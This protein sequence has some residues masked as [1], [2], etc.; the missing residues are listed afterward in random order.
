MTMSKSFPLPLLLAALTAL[1]LLP[2]A[3]QDEDKKPEADA[4]AE[5]VTI[6]ISSQ[7]DK[8]YYEAMA[9]AYAK[10]N[11]G[12]DARVVAYGFQEL[13][14]KLGAS[15]KTQTGL[16]DIVQIDEAFFGAFLN[17]PSPFVDLTERVKE[18]GLDKDLVENR[19]KLFT[20]EGKV[21]GLPQSLS[22]YVMFYRKD[23]FKDYGLTPKMF[24][25]WDDLERVGRTVAE[26]HGIATMSMDPTYF[27]V[28]LRQ[29]GSDLF[30]KDGK[31]LPDMEKATKLLEWMVKITKEGIAVLPERG[32]IFD[33]LFFS[34]QV[35]NDEVL[36]IMGADWYGLDLMPQFAPEL[37][38]KWGI[39]PIP[40][41]KKGGPRTSCFAGQA[42]MIVNGSDKTDEAWDFLHWVMTD[43]EA[44]A[45]RYLMG[46]S[47]PAYKPAWKD[48]RLQEGTEYFDGAAMGKVLI[49]LAKDIPPVAMSPNRPKALFLMQ[50]NYFSSAIYEVDT[51]ANILKD[52][53]KQIDE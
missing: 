10:K 45:K 41:W 27:E 36:M 46:N 7:Q 25:T 15:L 20:H 38:G 4:E 22:A 19:L 32:S 3:A 39:M 13:P 23:L 8:D 2:A 30:G 24:A 14:E 28:L 9:E 6:W 48:K 33:P 43:T 44:N 40:V 5:P 29:Q 35:A 21:R 26:D 16:P 37:A 12:F 42:L 50:E 11:E 31:A 53:K 47:F 52:F 34:S 17:G 18:S 1:F 51:P 49:K